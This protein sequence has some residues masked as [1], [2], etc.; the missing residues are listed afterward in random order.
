[1]ERVK[2]KIYFRADGNAQ[3]G[4]GHIFRS[5]ALAEMVSTDFD[6]Y[7]IVRN[8]LLI[9]KEQ[10]LATCN[11]IIE[12]E[13]TDD[14]IAEAKQISSL[15]NA[16]EIIV[17][18]GYHFITP[19]QQVFKEKDIKVVCIDDIHAYHFISD[20]VINHAG[21]MNL[22]DYSFEPYTK[23][24]LG[25]QY[26][27]LRKPFR[28]AAKNRKLDKPNNIFICL[29]GADPNNDTLGVLKQ[30]GQFDETTTCYLVLGGAYLHKKSLMTYLQN[31]SIKIEILQNLSAYE[32]VHY[33]NL[34]AKAITPPSTIAYEYLSTGGILYLKII[35]DNQIN[36]NRYFLNEG[37][38]FS[39][40]NYNQIAP[41]TI[42]N[43]I[44]KQ[45]ELLD[46]Y[47]DRRYIE[48]FKLLG[49]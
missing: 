46:G 28:E 21:G 23:F 31:S 1:M 12:L 20:V 42:I 32:M 26:A 25:L 11:G 30:I 40:D 10:I 35:A 45:K 3:M 15:I 4:L 47:S 36:I 2:R 48:I 14:S 43:T 49:Q 39:F 19:Y 8:P 16:G 34:C 22:K 9:L 17:L 18:D 29:G 38:A 33:M 24:F 44:N 7:F 41:I 27:L 37:L 5:L 13:D 6:C